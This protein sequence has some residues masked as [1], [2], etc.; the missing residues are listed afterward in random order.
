MSRFPL[1]LLGPLLA[2]GLLFLVCGPPA[3]AQT[4]ADAS[5]LP[6]EIATPP[7]PVPPRPAPGEPAEVKLTL[8]LNKLSEIDTVAETYHVDAYLGVR[9]RDPEGVELLRRPAGDERAVYLGDAVDDLLGSVVWWPDLELINTVG[10]RDRTAQRLEVFDDGMVQYTERF[11]ATLSSNMDFRQFPFDRQTFEILIESYTYRVD[12]LVFVEPAARLG[13]LQETPAPDWQL[14]D[15]RTRLTRH[16]YGDGWYARYTLAVEA[17]RL[18]GYFVWQ[19]FLPLFLILGT[20]WIVFWLTELSDKI[21]VAFT[22]LLT[23]VAFNFYTATMLPQLPYNTFIEVVVISAY[24][25]TFVLIAYILVAERMARADR[26]EA[27]ERLLR[28]GR[29]LFP[30]AYALSLALTALRFF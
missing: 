18:P 19:V 10:G 6:V 3:A 30:A 2:G 26:A 4:V 5:A 28:V 12:D 20:S 21:S 22:C 11:Q 29:W 24:V 14:G 27:S 25:A 13:H 8:T 9:W 16:E 7:A 15:P 1:A 17:D 23:L